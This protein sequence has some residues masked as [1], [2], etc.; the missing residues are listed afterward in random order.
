MKKVIFILILVVA[1]ISFVGCGGK[2]ITVPEKAK[3]SNPYY[4]A[5]LSTEDFTTLVLSVTNNTDKNIEIIWSRTFYIDSSGGTNGY[6]S[7]GKETF[8]EEK[9]YTTA[10][11]VIFPR[12]SISRILY[13]MA[14]RYWSKGWYWNNLSLGIN[15]VYLTVMAD[16]KE[17]TEKISFKFVIKK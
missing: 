15:G 14:N 11:A 5:S 1:S 17:I 16:G 7:F 4:T 3:A 2:Y 8:W 10:P 12:A 9:D 13:P 6:F